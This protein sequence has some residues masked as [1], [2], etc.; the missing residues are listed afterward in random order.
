MT[1][2]L[3][4]M[5]RLDKDTTGLLLLGS[6]GGLQTMLTHPSSLIT[7]QYLATLRPGF[8]LAADAAAQIAAGLELPDGTRCAPAELVVVELGLG[9]IVAL[10]DHLSTSYQIR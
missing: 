1:L 3:P 2:N 9:R 7:K 5:A 8:L 4:P 6:D 10:Y